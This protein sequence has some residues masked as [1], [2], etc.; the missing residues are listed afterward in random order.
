MP[1]NK[2]NITVLS[3]FLLGCKEQSIKNKILNSILDDSVLSDFLPA[4]QARVGIDQEGLRRLQDHLEVCASPINYYQAIIIGGAHRL[5]D[6]NDLA[7]LLEK[8]LLKSDDFTTI[9]HILSA[10]FTASERPIKDYSNQLIEIG[11]SLLDKYDFTIIDSNNDYYLSCISNICLTGKQ[12]EQ[13]MLRICKKIKQ[14]LIS[15]DIYDFSNYFQFCNTLAIKQAHIFLDV[16]LNSDNLSKEMCTG[17]HNPF[18]Y[19]KKEDAL[20]WCNLKSNERFGLLI[21][22]I[23][24]FMKTRENKLLWNPV[25]LSILD[26]APNIDDVLSNLTDFIISP[27][28]VS[29]TGSYTNVLEEKMDLLKELYNHK[30]IR[31]QSWAKI[32]F[33]T[34]RQ[35]VQSIRYKEEQQETELQCFE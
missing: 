30:E 4:F 5:I 26:Q 29:W 9:A 14:L 21:L 20:S 8:M 6:D 17:S 35:Q 24:V 22:W 2:R 23:S 12:A 28:M 19:I 7:A 18:D 31:V 11:R 1:T 34:L 25:I 16:F 15:G 13:V 33:E 32:Q 3:G 10:R 27:K